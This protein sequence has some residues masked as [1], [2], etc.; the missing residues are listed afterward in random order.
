M[1]PVLRSIA[2]PGFPFWLRTLKISSSNGVAIKVGALNV[3]PPSV[4]TAIS[5]RNTLGSLACLEYKTTAFPL[6]RN[7]GR[8]PSQKPV[9][10]LT[11]NTELQVTPPS[12]L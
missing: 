8:E 5:S 3:V 2:T 9:D 6:G 10:E 1:L 4:E 7:N 11:F 12:S